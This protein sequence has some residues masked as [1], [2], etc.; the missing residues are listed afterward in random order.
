MDTLTERDQAP[1]KDLTPEQA[2][3]YFE[4]KTRTLLGIS[5][6]EFLRRLDA[7]D[8]NDVLDDPEHHPTV[9]YLWSLSVIAR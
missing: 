9:G 3:E 4:E 5:G 7:G 1:V 2:R 8:Y 6:E